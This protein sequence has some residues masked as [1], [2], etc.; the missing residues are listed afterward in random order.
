MP[1]PAVSAAIATKKTK[2][3]VSLVHSNPCIW[4]RSVLKQ[5]AYHLGIENL[6]LPKMGI[7]CPCSPR[8]AC[9]IKE[10]T[11]ELEP[12]DGLVGLKFSLY[13]KNPKVSTL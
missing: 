8:P 11:T 4:V 10:R 6:A 1:L 13:L 12:Y 5:Y 3:C 9:I 2:P 7:Y